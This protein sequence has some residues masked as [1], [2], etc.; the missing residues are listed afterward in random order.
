MT[1]TLSK[2]RMVLD[3]MGGREFIAFGYI[4]EDTTTP[5][6]VLSIEREKFIDFGSP[7]QITI[8]IEPNDTLNENGG[9]IVEIL[10][11]PP[12]RKKRVIK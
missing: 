4:D 9:N 11:I 5:V 3:R 6:Q 12:G 1:V 8:T 10:T 2:S 7:T